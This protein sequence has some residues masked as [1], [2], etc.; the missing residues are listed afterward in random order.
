MEKTETQTEILTKDMTIGEVIAKYPF[1]A[2]IMIG[3]G[4]HCVGCGV[5]PY[6]TIEQGCLSHGMPEETLDNMM[7][8]LNEAV[9]NTPKE[10]K[11]FIIS[12]NAVVK[13]KEFMKEENKTD[14]GL[15]LGISS[16]G[17]C[18]R[19]ELS[20]TLEFADHVESDEIVLNNN[21]IDLYVNTMILNKLSDINID[22]IEDKNGAGFKIKAS[23]KKSNG[24]DSGCG[25]SH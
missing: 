14:C 25:C 20:Y 18:C 17:D 4:L 24:C 23:L 5:N 12:D 6:E 11:K 16:G 1:L 7:N 13:L 15:R 2:E 3:Y 10:E 8:E 9:A 21:G 19:D 22:Y